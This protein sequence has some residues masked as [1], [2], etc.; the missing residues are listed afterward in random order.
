MVPNGVLSEWEQGGCEPELQIYGRFGQE[1]PLL[2][3]SHSSSILHFLSLHCIFE[4]PAVINLFIRKIS[5]FQMRFASGNNEM[6]KKIEDYS[7][8]LTDMIGKG[9]SSSVFRGINEKTREQVAI[10]VI[11]LKSLR[12]RPAKQM[13]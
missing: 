3:C 7:Y 1:H 5:K 9:F 6:R 10:K 12:D 13:L 11:D 4:F 8:G 2:I